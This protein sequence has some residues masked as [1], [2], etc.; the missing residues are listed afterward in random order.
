MSLTRSLGVVAGVAASVVL[1]AGCAG[2]GTDSTSNSRDIVKIGLAS[3]QTGPT[4]SA[5][6]ADK[7]GLEAYLGKLNDEGGVNGHKLEIVLRDTK[8][9]PV[10]TAS[11]A[12]EFVRLDVFVA[13]VEGTLPTQASRQVLAPAGIPMFA[14]AD[15]ATM[16]PP[17]SDLVFGTLYD[18][19]QIAAHGADFIKSHLGIGDIAISYVNSDAGK[20]VHATLP[21]YMSSHGGSV[22]GDVPI[23]TG[24]TDYAPF[25]QTLK[26]SGA[27]AVYAGLLDTQ[28]AAL[29]KASDAIGYSPKWVAWPIAQTPSF[30]SL[31]GPLSEGTFFTQVA[32]VLGDGGELSGGAKEYEEAVRALCPDLVNQAQTKMGWMTGMGIK[33]GIENATKD[34]AKLTRTNFLEGVAGDA[35]DL[36]VGTVTWSDSNRS[37]AATAG[38][39]ELKGGQL[40]EVAPFSPVP[41]TK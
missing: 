1:I 6:T 18:F 7:C 29:Q 33:R 14:S 39:Y 11:I 21:D 8:Y 31:A 40:M 3:D 16:N 35:I 38:T 19:R 5:G 2:P 22:V 17:Q 13:V 9:D 12:R 30:A 36:G 4:A 23:P 10:R 34:G 25:A 20:S 28:L 26:D 24:T 41:T 27:D 32:S 15:G 37:G